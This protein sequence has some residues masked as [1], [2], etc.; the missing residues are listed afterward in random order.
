MSRISWRG[1]IACGALLLGTL[2]PGGLAYAQGVG[3]GQ[4]GTNQNGNKQNVNM[5]ATPELDSVLLFG[6]GAI[7]VAGFGLLK[8]RAARKSTKR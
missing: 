4:N 1:S 8:L 2:G 7:G 5:A 3:T 6:T